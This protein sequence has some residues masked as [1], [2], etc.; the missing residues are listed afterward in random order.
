VVEEE[1]EETGRGEGV[2]GEMFPK[3]VGFWVL[4]SAFLFSVFFIILTVISFF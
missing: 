1:E 4:S 3:A 2:R